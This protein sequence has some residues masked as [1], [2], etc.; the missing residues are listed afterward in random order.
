MPKQIGKIHKMV[1]NGEMVLPFDITKEI[2]TLYALLVLLAQLHF[3]YRGAGFN[4][5][6]LST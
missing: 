1:V 2:T 5:Y 4:Y 6:M 3:I